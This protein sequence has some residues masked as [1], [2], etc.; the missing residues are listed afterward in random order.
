MNPEKIR[1][2]VIDRV[3]SNRVSIKEFIE[4]EGAHTVNPE[5]VYTVDTLEDAW[6]GLKYIQSTHDNGGL[7]KVIIADLQLPFAK[8][9]C[10]GISRMREFYKERGLAVPEV[11]IMTGD[12]PWSIEQK[13]LDVA[14]MNIL[15]K[16][17]TG[18]VLM[19]AVGY[20]TVQYLLRTAAVP[21]L[22]PSWAVPA[23]T[24]IETKF[25]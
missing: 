1:I 16:P 8:R 9:W 21:D 5:K 24:G 22:N 23:A 14:G 18:D 15:K 25:L 2:L 7:V 4:D 20:A 3:P 17:L 13:C 19:A 6:G 12:S 11:I 10:E